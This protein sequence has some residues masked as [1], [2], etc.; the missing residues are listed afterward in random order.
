MKAVIVEL[1]D[2]YVAALSQDGRILKIKN[3]NYEIGQEI[4]MKE[5]WI[6]NRRFVKISAT[7]AASFMLFVAPAWAYLTPYSYVSLDVNPSVEYTVNIFDR[8]LSVKAVNDDGEEILKEMDIDDLKN[9]NIE[10]AV[11]EVINGIIDAG[12]FAEGEE[13]GVMIAASSKNDEKSQELAD[14]LKSKVEEKIKEESSESE[15]EVE[16]VIVGEERVEEARKL[17]VTPGKLNL[18]QKLQESSED[19]DDIDVEEWLNKP[20]KEIMQATKENKKA[21]KAA[22]K[23]A[24]NEEK[25]GSKDNETKLENDEDLETEIEI[26]EKKEDINLEKIKLKEKKVADKE[27]KTEEKIESKETKVADKEIKTEEKIESKETKAAD[28]EIKTEE[29]IES[30]ETKAADKEIKTEEKIESKETKKEEKAT[31]K[32]INKS[33]E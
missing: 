11:Q 15:V 12:F 23:E 19:S 4:I 30:K 28:K 33:S 29:K 2:N 14:K 31:D 13:G 7:V 17:G 18:V 1:R 8:V 24:K 9:K 27:I 6:K 26:E 25:I 22:E 3:D 16:A 5:Q 10:V 32:R 21:I 20:V